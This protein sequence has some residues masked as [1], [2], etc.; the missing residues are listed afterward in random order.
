MALVLVASTT[1]DLARAHDFQLGAITIDHP[2][3]VP[4]AASSLQGAIYV[5]ELR[6]AS[7]TADRLVGASASVATSVQIRHSASAGDLIGAL[8]T[9]PI[10]LPARSTVLL[11]HSGQWQ[12]VLVGLK[13]PL[14]E[15][16]WFDVTLHFERAGDKRV[17]VAVQT[18][19]TKPQ[20]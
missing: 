7:D 20:P 18:P 6:N 2:Y 3:A 17:K 12:L 9:G 10:D 1:N 14:V 4:S 16:D 19:R 11:R 8:H 15:G 13:A 5:R